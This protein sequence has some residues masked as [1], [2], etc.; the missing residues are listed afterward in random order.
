MAIE[1]IVACTEHAEDAG[2][3]EAEAAGQVGSLALASTMMA[4]LL[5]NHRAF[6]CRPCAIGR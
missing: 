6:A 1:H 4:Y 5:L 2:M 3:V